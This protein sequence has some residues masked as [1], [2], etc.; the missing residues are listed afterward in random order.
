MVKNVLVVDSDKGFSTILSETLNNHADFKATAVP[1]STHALQFV[2]EKP[3]DL[4]IIDMGLPDMPVP[5]LIKAIREA[6]PTMAIMVIPF[7]GEDVPEE[8]KNMGLQGILP[9]PFF[10]GDLPKLVGQAVGLEFESQVPDLPPAPV[11]EKPAKSRPAPP[12][13]RSTPP[14]APPPRRRRRPGPSSETR[15]RSAPP[16]ARTSAASLPMLPSWKLE[17]L[18]KNK[19]K[20]VNDLKNLNGEIRAEVILLTAGSE[21]I[22]TAGTMAE[23][24][25]QEL[26]LL[27]AESAEAASQAAAFLGERDARFEQSLHE[28]N[29]FRLYSY[30]LGQGVV[31]SLALGMNVPL[32]ILR[33]QTKQTGQTLMKYIR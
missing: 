14:P 22:A 30:S 10:V 3:V 12:P 11:E 29:E 8:I 28:G 18:R 24:R 6:K 31:L 9:K 1:V 2:V 26:A 32:G 27:V 19:D 23:D 25:A 4:V 15:S 20:I 33:H 7:I 17:Q 5:K 13:K 16:P 21:L